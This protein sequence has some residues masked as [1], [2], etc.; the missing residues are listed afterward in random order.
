M[1]CNNCGKTLTKD[2][3][4][5]HYCGKEVITNT[6]KKLKTEFNFSALIYGILLSILITLLLYYFSKMLGLPIFI[7]GIFLPFLWR[8][9]V[10]SKE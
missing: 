7:G 10:K 8:K 9:V 3:R 5:C 1:N 6:N 4:F 2:S